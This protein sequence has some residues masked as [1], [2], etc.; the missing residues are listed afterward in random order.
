MDV[1]EADGDGAD[2][3]NAAAKRVHRRPAA[4]Q[5]EGEHAAEALRKQPTGDVVVGV[6]DEAG[7]PHPST[8][9]WA[10]EGLATAW[11]FALCWP[12]AQAERAHAA[13]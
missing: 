1:A 8:A 10:L 11:A 7:I 5:L 9:S 4:A 13:R 12:H 3:S 6:A 2:S